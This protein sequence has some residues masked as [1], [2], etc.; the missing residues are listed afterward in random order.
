[1][2]DLQKFIAALTALSTTHG[3]KIGGCGCCGSPWVRKESKAGHYSMP[4]D[5]DEDIDN[6]EWVKE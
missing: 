5:T 2:T 1:M 6:L 3:F 4:N